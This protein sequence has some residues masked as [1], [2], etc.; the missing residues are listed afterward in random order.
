MG[1]KMANFDAS[2]S[3][4]EFGYRAPATPREIAAAFWATAVG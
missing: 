1:D 4:E 2:I 3:K